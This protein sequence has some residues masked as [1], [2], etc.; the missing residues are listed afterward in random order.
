MASY[1]LADADY[2][3]VAEGLDVLLDR[4]TRARRK[5][6]K[7]YAARRPGQRRLR[8]EVKRLEGKEIRIK[9]LHNR[10]GGT[11]RRDIAAWS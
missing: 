10:M 2:N 11:L 1:D 9:A 4:T 3:L 7:A 8:E 5:A 6:Q